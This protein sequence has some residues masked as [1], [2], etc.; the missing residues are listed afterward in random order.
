MKKNNINQEGSTSLVNNASGTAPALRGGS[1][2]GFARR[3]RGSTMWSTLSIT[4]M[5]G[6]IAFLAFHLIPVYL[7]H[8]IIRS[9]MQEIVNAH[10]FKQMSTKQIQSTI[11]KRMTID[12]IRGFDKGAFT[13]VRGKK[14]TEKYIM[15]DYS[16]KIPLFSNVFALVEFKEE[17]RTSR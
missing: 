13:V 12:N 9:S 2:Q 8:G 10:N 17:I 11:A 6:F 1:R 3:Q 16:Q 5:V 15:I 4:L 14:G 7:D